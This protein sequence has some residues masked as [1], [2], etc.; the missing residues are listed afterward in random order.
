MSHFPRSHQN[1]SFVVQEPSD[2]YSYGD[3]ALRNANDV[4]QQ[5]MQR[6][7]STQPRMRSPATSVRSTARAP[8]QQRP[9][10]NPYFPTQGNA[11]SSNNGPDHALLDIDMLAPP[12]HANQSFS[13]IH[14]HMSNDE[15]WN[16]LNL[17][18]EGVYSNRS[19]FGHG[20]GSLRPYGQGPGSVGSAAPRS[21]SGYNSQSVLS[22]DAGRME[23]QR[24][25]FGLIQQ[26]DDL[27][28][29]STPA[30]ATPMTRV[31]SDQR[32]QVS[33][34]SNRSSHRGNHLKCD[35][36]GWVS[37]CNSDLKYVSR[38]KWILHH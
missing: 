38:H 12:G 31:A 37:K 33:R 8:V 13:P 36:C 15:S 29:H 22:H 3:P 28:T 34:L 11:T 1:F 2:Q 17:R 35:T 6:P 19:S 5:W 21:D 4:A 27:S 25:L 7:Q 32:S 26:I 30:E 16:S 24:P 9:F 10:D 18:N 23:S 20:D 14:R